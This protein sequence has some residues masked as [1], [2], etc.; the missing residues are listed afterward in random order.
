MRELTPKAH[1]YI[2]YVVGDVV[3]NSEIVGASLCN[4]G[5]NPFAYLVSI[6]IET[7]ERLVVETCNEL[8]HALGLLPPGKDLALGEMGDYCH[9]VRGASSEGECYVVNFNHP[10]VLDFRDG[11]PECQFILKNWD[12]CDDDCVTAR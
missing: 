6:P 4:D 2:D 1:E 8:F 3:G 9:V 7:D 10:A 12:F 11:D 5:E